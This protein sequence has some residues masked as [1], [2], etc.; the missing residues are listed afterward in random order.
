MTHLNINVY[1]FTSHKSNVDPNKIVKSL[2]GIEDTICV[3]ID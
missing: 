1:V 2:A 3:K